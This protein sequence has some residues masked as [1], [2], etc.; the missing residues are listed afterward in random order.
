MSERPPSSRRSDDGALALPESLLAALT[1]HGWF[2]ALAKSLAGQDADDLR[3]DVALRAIVH[4]PSH[5]DH[6]PWLVTVLR[7]RAAALAR[8]RARRHEREHEHAQHE[9]IADEEPPASR[10]ELRAIV[11]RELFALDEPY[12]ATLVQR[13]LEERSHAEIARLEGIPIGTVRWRQ[14]EGLAL[15]RKR[16]DRRYG[17]RERW[18]ATLLPIA[19]PET[20]AAV[21]AGVLLMKA[22]FA[23]AVSMLVAIGVLLFAL[24]RSR[25]T[26]APEPT[27]Q[28][29][30]GAPLDA[31]VA[32]EPAAQESPRREVV[33]DEPSAESATSASAGIRLRAR[34]LD[35]RGGPVP[36]VALRA[37]VRSSE[38]IRP[39]D[40]RSISG[41]DGVATIALDLAPEER[42][43]FT[44]RVQVYFRF[45]P[46]DHL[47]CGD[48]A[49]ATPGEELDLGDFV[50]RDA[51]RIA[52]R[53]VDEHGAG[54]PFTLVNVADPET[55][56][57][58]AHFGPVPIAP[59]TQTDER[60]EFELAGVAPGFATIA[61]SD[62]RVRGGNTITVAVNAGET[63]RCADL[64]LRADSGPR[65]HGRAI[66]G[67]GR[68]LSGVE[69]TLLG[70][71]GDGPRVEQSLYARSDDSGRFV[72]R[73]G[74]RRSHDHDRRFVLLAFDSERRGDPVRIDSVAPTEA[75]LD[76][77]LAAK[78]PLSLRLTA[79]DGSVVERALVY[80]S[81][82]EAG[83]DVATISASPFGYTR[84]QD[85]IVPLQRPAT[86]FSIRVLASGYR[87]RSLGPF[88]PASV[89]PEINATLDPVATIRGRVVAAGKPIAGARVSLVR[90]V[91]NEDGFA[92][93]ALIA[94]AFP[95]EFAGVAGVIPATTD[96][97][98]SFAIAPNGDGEFRVH[99]AAR[100]FGSASSGIFS[101]S[102]SSP[103]SEFE[104]DLAPAGAIEGVLLGDST[105]PVARRVVGASIGDGF[106]RTL[107]TDGDGRF[108]FDDLEPGEWLVALSATEIDP[109]WGASG[110]VLG[111]RAPEPPAHAVRVF[112]REGETSRVTL[113]L[114]TAT[115]PVLR[116][117]I[118]VENE[119]PAPHSVTAV[120][121]EDSGQRIAT[122]R[123]ARTTAMPDG[124]FELMLDRAGR[125][126]LHLDL[127]SVLGIAPL[128]VTRRIEIRDGVNS[129]A[130]EVAFC[131]IEITD[132]EPGEMFR[133]EQDDRVTGQTAQRYLHGRSG[134]AEQRFRVLP[135][136]GRIVRMRSPDDA[137]AFA[138]D[139]TFSPIEFV[140]RRGDRV[141]V[142]LA[143]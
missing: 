121:I 107:R 117:I 71:A 106:V 130:I 94:G 10:D 16:L 81:L 11:A 54:V 24:G 17:D 116:G 110:F 57:W 18:L 29:P 96:S 91:G 1:D 102:V 69:L 26:P 44:D 33:R 39:S 98:G 89:G 21:T 136:A 15:L 99:A 131:E 53:V 114:R 67:A 22:K 133:I 126:A 36:G 140:A 25:S 103:P 135:G 112:V 63:T 31:R 70:L 5:H 72:F 137:S 38:T 7:R 14:H 78:E 66:D 143:R 109:S 4:P 34:F 60:G 139:P 92:S 74:E 47:A 118:R 59:S 141:V 23:L 124:S 138:P 13:F 100:G 27:P 41:D 101:Y 90:R 129:L 111:E 87:S 127:D 80:M 8:A 40:P 49:L 119:A 68:P 46:A 76:V 86:A 51:G 32:E 58:V 35:G 85:G 50:L 93:V 19:R 120:E 77:V 43:R 95:S 61:A 132:I 125:Y 9:S 115:R 64:V 52:G 88:D 56:P 79:S 108:R 128:T 142:S 55:N 83:E 20:S 12:R 122:A 42:L 105:E 30:T 62:A 84:H 75:P 73:L 3:Q 82:L 45:D 134:R 37:N 65:V 6:G 48:R 97:D 113:D 104:V 2:R 123:T 28:S